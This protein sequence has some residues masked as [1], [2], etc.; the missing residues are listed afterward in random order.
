[1]NGQH[2]GHAH[3]LGR[4]ATRFIVLGFA[5]VIL[6]GALL[7]STPAATWDGQGIPFL[8]A[9]FTATSAVCVT[10][11]V[12]VDTAMTFSIFGQVVILLLIQVGGLGFMTVAMLFF[13]LLGKRVT[14]GTRLLFQEALNESRIGGLVRMMRWVIFSAFT[15]EGIGTAL[16]ATRFVPIFGLGQGLWYSLFHAISAFCNAGFD[17]IGNYQNM[18]PFWFDPVINWTLMLLIVIGGLGFGVLRDIKKRRCFHELRLHSKLVLTFTALMILG[19]TLLILAMEWSNPD[20]LGS[21]NVF[22]KIQAAFFQ[23]ITLRTAGFNTID[24]AALRPSTKLLSIVMMFIGASPAST[25]GGVKVTTMA[26]IILTVRMVARGRSEISAF[27][28]TLP[29]DLVQRSMSIVFIGISV[30]LVDVMA[31]TLLQPGVDFLDLA[32]ECASALGTVGVSSLG[33]ATLEP[34]A[35]FLLILTMY[36]GRIG[37]LSLT[38]AIGHRQAGRP[39]GY[40]C[41]VERVLGG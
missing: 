29:R 7:L 9:L 34:L 32:F 11:L 14:L 23:S 26:V 10:G 15:I 27:R 36:I 16:L 19:G 37:P 1:M 30:L 40:R 6:V 28:R 22:Q 5:L 12:V 20:T 3:R 2:E 24:Q 21:M 25:G 33:T 4:N 17:L 31:L 8:D 13:M 18:T 35:K 38:L 39:V 41:A